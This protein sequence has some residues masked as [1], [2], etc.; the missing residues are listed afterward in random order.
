MSNSRTLC[1][2]IILALTFAGCA[3]H[4]ASYEAKSARNA[5]ERSATASPM[6]T[7]PRVAQQPTLPGW[8]NT[9]TPAYNLR[10][11]MERA[12]APLALTDEQIVGISETVDE[13][14]IEQAKFAQKKTKNPL[15]RKFAKDVISRHTK[16]RQEGQNL[17]KE[18]QLGSAQSPVASDLQGKSNQ[19]LELLKSA[20]ASDFDRTYADSQIEQHQAALDLLNNQLIPNASNPELKAKLQNERV[21]LERHLN[22]VREIQRTLMRS[23][24]MPSNSA[25]SPTHDMPSRNTPPG[26]SP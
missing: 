23:Q 20:D 24:A 22:E 15:L 9:P 8:E 6:Q 19:Q 14:E 26:M 7:I 4:G 21:M 1:M 10:P 3:K 12:V 13:N 17:A 16:S 2:S 11:P 18:A 25:E 5:P